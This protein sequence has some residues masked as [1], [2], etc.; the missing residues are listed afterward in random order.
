MSEAPFRPGFEV[1]ARGFQSTPKEPTDAQQRL[2]DIMSRSLVRL[3]RTHRAFGIEMVV[4]LAS[5][6]A[7]GWVIS[8]LL[9]AVYAQVV[10][11]LGLP[12]WL[13]YA[14]V[15][16]PII[17][18]AVW[19]EVRSRGWVG[20]IRFDSSQ[21]RPLITFERLTLAIGAGWAGYAVIIGIVLGTHAG[22]IHRAADHCGLTSDP[23]WRTCLL[24]AADN[25]SHGTIDVVARQFGLP[26]HDPLEHSR[27]S[28][29][30]FLLISISIDATVIALAIALWK[31]RKVRHLAETFKGYAAPLDY[32]DL[33]QYLR[34][35]CYRS[36]SWSNVYHDEFVFFCI[37]EKYLSGSFGQ[38]R[39]LAGLFPDIDLPDEIRGLF[40]DGRGQ[41]LLPTAL[42]EG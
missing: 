16:F 3:F 10:G 13:L 41:P 7:C 39:E 14:Y 17:A 2:A 27:T 18:L 40:T 30:I 34:Q 20:Q 15:L 19:I 24:I 12:V 22:L 8:W 35:V 11:W 4:A 26:R 28:K 6:V 42:E 32:E 29:T 23:G 25:A 36:R 33:R 5:C 1:T 9:V 37:V 38:C 31:R 21:S